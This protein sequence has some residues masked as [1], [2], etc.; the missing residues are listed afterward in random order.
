MIC[1]IRHEN[2][3]SNK[4]ESASRFFT[5][6]ASPLPPCPTGQLRARLMLGDAVKIKLPNSI[7]RT[8]SCFFWS[9]L[10]EKPQESF[11]HVS[12]KAVNRVVNT[13]SCAQTGASFTTAFIKVFSN[14][15]FLVWVGG[16]VSKSTRRGAHLAEECFRRW[17]PGGF[18]ALIS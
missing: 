9:V 7:F 8:E 2:R 4:S 11:L 17:L 12:L 10:M 16:S 3:S 13:Q 6:P 15:V 18:C 14:C 5:S 1:G